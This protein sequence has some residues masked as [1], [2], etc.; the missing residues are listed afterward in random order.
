V[1]GTQGDASRGERTSM[2]LTVTAGHLPY[3]GEFLRDL[4]EAADLAEP[5]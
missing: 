2:H 5:A 3:I 1:L 4:T